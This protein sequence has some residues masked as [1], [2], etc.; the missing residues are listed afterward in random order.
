MV[1][2][3]IVVALFVV[4]YVIE[5]PIDHVAYAAP[6]ERVACAEPRAGH[7][8]SLVV[9]LCVSQRHGDLR[10]ADGAAD[11]L[12]A[13]QRNRASWTLRSADVTHSFWVPAFLFKRD[14]IPGM[15]NVFDITPN[16][17]GS[18]LGTLRAVLRTR[19]RADDVYGARR[20]AGAIPAHARHAARRRR[21]RV[22]DDD[23]SQEDRHHVRG[24]DD[25][26]LRGGRRAGAAHSHAT[27]RA[28]Q[29]VSRA[30]RLQSSVHAARHADD[31]LRHRAVRDR[32]WR[33]IWCRCKSA[34]P[35]LR[36]RG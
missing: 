30:A 16:R 8:V 29:L 26:V 1:P 11:A 18:F 21:D 20:A 22:A 15:T 2:L 9:A 12:S 24:G 14:A 32:P 31:L 6:G 10:H 34:R 3:L 4:T 25:V 19:S 27:G 13:A 36:F 23:R 28:R 17:A 5:M 33:T 35:T 7:R